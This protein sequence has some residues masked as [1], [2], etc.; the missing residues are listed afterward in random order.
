MHARMAPKPPPPQPQTEANGE[1]PAAPPTAHEVH[2]EALLDFFGAKVKAQEMLTRTHELTQLSQ[3]IQSYEAPTRFRCDGAL[4]QKPPSW[5]AEVGWDAVNDAML[6]L[7][8]HLYGFGSWDRVREDPELGLQ[9]KLPGSSQVPGEDGKMPGGLPK[10]NQVES[11]A[12]MLLRK[13]M[14]PKAPKREQGHAGDGRGAGGTVAHKD[15]CNCIICKQRRSRVDRDSSAEPRPRPHRMP[16]KN[17]MSEPTQEEIVHDFSPII[18][19]LKKL[20][21]LQKCSADMPKEKVIDKTRKY[22]T[23]V[24]R[25]VD[26]LVRRRTQSG[27]KESDRLRSRLWAYVAKFR[28]GLDGGRLEVIYSKLKTGPPSRGPGKPAG[29]EAR[30]GTSAH[31]AGSGEGNGSASVHAGRQ[32]SGSGG[33]GVRPVGTAETQALAQAPLRM[34]PKKAS[35]LSMQN[36]MNHANNAGSN[37]GGAAGHSAGGSIG[38]MNGEAR[39]HQRGEGG[40]NGGHQRP[41]ATSNPPLRMV[42]RMHSGGS[43]EPRDSHPTS[44]GRRGLDHI[45]KRPRV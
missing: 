30:A 10:L 29:G 43:M 7:G 39:P 5:A 25:H 26:T 23:E 8:V 19:T 14:S 9:D 2:K 18:K 32:A 21:T 13:M 33:E 42:K 35:S 28:P 37:R 36:R 44:P 22:L 1:P 16:Q 6:L 45:P 11:R 31:H 24:G 17:C 41:H 3:I 34:I 40:M 4:R 38:G 27:S 15:G 12:A 20:R